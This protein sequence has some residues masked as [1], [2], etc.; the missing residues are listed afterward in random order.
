[1]SACNYVP[2]QTATLDPMSPYFE[3][4]LDLDILV[5]DEGIFINVPNQQ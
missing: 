3:D 1:M 4:L 2:L 5:T